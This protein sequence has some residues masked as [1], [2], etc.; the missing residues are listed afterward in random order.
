VILGGGRKIAV[1]FCTDGNIVC[2][3]SALLMLELGLLRMSEPESVIG[4][5]R[6]RAANAV[7]SGSR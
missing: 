7:V 5:A 6:R 4:G 1:L 2:E 3:E